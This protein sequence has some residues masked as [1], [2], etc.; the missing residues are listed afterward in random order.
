MNRIPL[1][2][3]LT[4]MPDADRPAFVAAAD[5]ARC[6]AILGAAWTRRGNQILD[7]DG[8]EQATLVHIADAAEQTEAADNPGRIVVD[9]TS[10]TIIPL[11]NLI[12]ARRDRPDSLYAM[13]RTPEQC[14]VFRDTLDVGVHGVVLRPGSPEAIAAAHQILLDKGPRPDDRRQESSTMHLVEARI[15]RI[16]DAGPGDRVCI[17][18]SSELQAGEGVLVGSRASGFAL[19]G[20]EVEESEF[21]RARP[22]RIN[23]GALH[24]YVVAPDGR[25]RYL[26]ELAAGDA[27]LVV[28]EAGA[29]TVTIG[30]AKLERRPHLLVRWIGPHGA[31]HVVV[32]NA[33]TIRFLGPHGAVSVTELAPGDAIWIHEEHAARHFGMPIDERLVER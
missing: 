21:V 24:N 33:E 14:G 27:V 19:L 8:I 23:A 3:D 12:A 25:T 2:I 16:E 29:R 7:G 20:A 31:G 11:E 5:A 9:A 15:E 30:R 13:A 26:S 1:W 18:T 17:D 6:E 28:S 32:Q 10:W 4:E 22:F